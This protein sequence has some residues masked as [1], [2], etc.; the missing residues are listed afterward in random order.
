LGHVLLSSYAQA[1]ARRCG[2]GPQRLEAARAGLA[3]AGAL[4]CT[5]LPQ[6]P[7]LPP[8]LELWHTRGDGIAALQAASTEEKLAV[9]ACISGQSLAVQD[10]DLLP[11][12]ADAAGGDEE[13]NAAAR[14]AGFGAD[15]GG[16]PALSDG[17]GAGA[18]VAPASERC[19][20]DEG[21]PGGGNENDER[22]GG[23]GP[24]PS[25]RAPSAETRWRGM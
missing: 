8:G 23:G 7:G 25:A 3:A 20:V 10:V 18:A 24:P 1:W 5:P 13:H 19:A 12:A 14:A 4:A 6:A 2:I 22:G 21:G 16:Q 17:G 15:D 11:Q 9:Q